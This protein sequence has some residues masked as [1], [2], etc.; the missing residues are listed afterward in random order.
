MIDIDQKSVED[1][2]ICARIQSY[3]NLMQSRTLEWAAINTG[4]WN[5]EGLEHLA[6]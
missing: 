2:D 4:S 5:R 3:E 1:E 6:Q